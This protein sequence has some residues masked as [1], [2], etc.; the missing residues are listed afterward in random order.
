MASGH[1]AKRAV[2]SATTSPAASDASPW[3]AA[4]RAACCCATESGTSQ[5]TATRPAADSDATRRGSGRVH[6]RRTTRRRARR[7]RRVRAAHAPAPTSGVRRLPLVGGVEAGVQRRRG[8]A[9]RA[10]AGEFL[11]DFVAVQGPPAEPRGNSARERCLAGCGRPADQEQPHLCLRQMAER[12]AQQALCLGSLGG[13]LR[14]SERRNLR[15]HQRRG[16]RYRNVRVIPASRHRAARA[17][18]SRNCLPR[19][20]VRVARGPW[21]RTRRRRGRRRTAAGR[22]TRG[23]R[24]HE[25]RRRGSRRL[26]REGRHARHGRDALRFGIRT[27]ARGM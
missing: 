15:P 9:R 19:T 7:T 3:V 8:R 6:P 26:R 14:V 20:P 12:D 4:R 2:S 13:R 27:A 17:Y 18:V 22:R 24:A 10:D 23:S 11:A 21:P 16:R 25:V 1:G 5:R